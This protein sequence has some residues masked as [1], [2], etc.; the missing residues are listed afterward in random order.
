[1]TEP[2][3]HLHAEDERVLD[4]GIIVER[5]SDLMLPSWNASLGV[6]LPNPVD[7]M[8]DPPAADTPDDDEVSIETVRDDDDLKVVQAGAI[9]AVLTSAGMWELPSGETP[10]TAAQNTTDTAVAD[11][12]EENVYLA[13][14]ILPQSWL[15]NAAA[16]TAPKPRPSAKSVRVITAS[17]SS[18]SSAATAWTS[19]M[20]SDI[21][22]SS[23]DL[24][25]DMVT[26]E[27]PEVADE[28]LANPQDTD[29]ATE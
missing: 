18:S 8:I 7:S 14:A 6:G 21:V 22:R 15:Q 17:T 4:E 23:G 20:V 13:G 9:Q 27:S 11:S 16:R 1:M 24:R 12:D 5:F 25:R 29:H 2:T 26:S 19:S 3:Q 10:I 28:A